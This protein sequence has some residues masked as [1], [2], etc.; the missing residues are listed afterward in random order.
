MTIAKP[1]SPRLRRTKAEQ[2]ALEAQVVQISLQLF[3]EGGGE[4]V[5]MRKI[6]SEVGVPPMSL[7]RYFP[8]KAHLVR[9]I[10]QDLLSRACAEGKLE[11]ARCSG[12]LHKLR[13][14]MGGFLRHWLKHRHHYWFVFC[15]HAAPDLTGGDQEAEPIRPDPHEVLELISRLLAQCAGSAQEPGETLR[16]LAEELLCYALGFLV[17]AVGLVLKTPAEIARLLERLLDSMES[18]IGAELGAG[19]AA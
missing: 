2:S 5:S 6:A 11:A 17:T 13:A 3:T 15:N 12:P 18:R 19:V 7:Y 9:H 8:S 10:W 4:A 14:F 1:A 16:H